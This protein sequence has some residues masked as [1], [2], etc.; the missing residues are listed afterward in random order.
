MLTASAAWFS[1][2]LVPQLLHGPVAQP[3]CQL[4]LPGGCCRWR[5]LE[6]SDPAA[7]ELIQKVQLLQRRLI[8]AS[9]RLVE[10]DLQIQ[11]K[12]QLCHQLQ[13]LVKRSPGPDAAAALALSQVGTP[14]PPSLQPCRRP[15]S[16]SILI[17]MTA[18][19]GG[20]RDGNLRGDPF[21]PT[22]MMPARYL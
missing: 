22:I 13:A 6:G 5:K 20:Y 18:A 1:W 4:E 11:E 17:P 2:L 19:S 16:R 9:E 3:V 10:R 8:R 21:M 12:E 7:Y 14:A 15:P